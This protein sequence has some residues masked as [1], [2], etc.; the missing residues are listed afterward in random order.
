MPNKW[1]CC[2]CL[3]KEMLLVLKLKKWLIQAL[4]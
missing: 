4:V 2:I 1:Y 3:R